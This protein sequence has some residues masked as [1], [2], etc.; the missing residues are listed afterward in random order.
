[1]HKPEAD[2]LHLL[3]FAYI[4]DHFTQFEHALAGLYFADDEFGYKAFIEPESFIDMYFANEITK[5]VSMR[6]DRAPISTKRKT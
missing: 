6:I 3:Q 1:M 4:Q 5:N 2:D